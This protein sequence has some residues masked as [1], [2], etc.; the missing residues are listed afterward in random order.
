MLITWCC[1][2]N[3]VQCF[4]LPFKWS[5]VSQN[6]VY[7]CARWKEWRECIHGH[8]GG[9]FFLPINNLNRT[10]FLCHTVPLFT[11]WRGEG[12]SGKRWGRNIEYATSVQSCKIK[13]TDLFRPEDDHVGTCRTPSKQKR[14]NKW[15]T[16]YVCR[17]RRVFITVEVLLL[18]WTELDS[19]NSS[20]LGSRVLHSISH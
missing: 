6:T 17:L 2:V 10:H 13:L 15:V 1:W 5:T 20:L 8:M 3:L 16:Q 4:R 14:L 7:R 9:F 19:G 11:I 18:S 12:S